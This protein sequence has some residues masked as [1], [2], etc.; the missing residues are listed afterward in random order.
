[1][2]KVNLRKITSKQMY[3]QT[4]K[5]TSEQNKTTLKRYRSIVYGQSIRAFL[6]LSDKVDN[7]I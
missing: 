2:E 5:Q 4:N 3:K 1:M 6:T 7:F